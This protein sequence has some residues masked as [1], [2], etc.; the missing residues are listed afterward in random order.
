MSAT[1]V[2]EA[3][4][5]ISHYA[6]RLQRRIDN[7]PNELQKI[8]ALVELATLYA[9]TAA[10][11]AAAT[12]I[13]RAHYLAGNLPPAQRALGQTFA[14]Y[15]DGLLAFHAARYSVA[16]ST[17][18]NT[19]EAARIARCEVI[20]ARSLAMLSLI[21]GR[22]GAQREAL[23]YGVSA[24]EIALKTGD[25]RAETQAR[26]A[27]GNLYIER[28]EAAAATAE[29]VAANKA[30]MSLNDPLTTAAVLS[31]LAN[32]ASTAAKLALVEYKSSNKDGDKCRDVLATS[33]ATCQTVLSECRVSGNRYAEVA[34]L[35]NL[36][37]MHF[38]ECQVAEALTLINDALVV[39]RLAQNIDQL[40]YAL[41]L[42]G[43]YLAADTQIDDA[44]A[45]LTEGLMH[46][47]QSGF[48]DAQT[49]IHKAVAE[50]YEAKNEPVAALAAY[51]LHVAGLDTQQL[52]ERANR[53]KM[54]EVRREFDQMR[55][56]IT[57]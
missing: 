51:K 11:D 53:Q 39:A 18:L 27:L 25:A 35:G 14:M 38:I 13:E 47:K 9:K 10:S 5:D 19:I 7:A 45:S 31:N 36:A 24:L 56:R 55:G 23:E 41:Y 46:A 33:F 17:I 48:Q 3:A 16:I 34:A 50:C 32:A 8:E 2:V 52:A 28:D 12:A 6:Q 21:S 29:F 49:R 15:G 42:R 22:L 4:T 30:S 40:A 54:A 26:V 43:V 20:R 37:E 57:T 44:L 1:P